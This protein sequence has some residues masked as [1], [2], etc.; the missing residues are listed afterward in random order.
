M[1]PDTLFTQFSFAHLPL[2]LNTFAQDVFR[3]AQTFP[4]VKL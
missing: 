1:R 2:I 4:P 3:N